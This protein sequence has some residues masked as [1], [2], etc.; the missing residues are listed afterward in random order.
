MCNSYIVRVFI[1]NEVFSYLIFFKE[2]KHGNIIIFYVLAI[3]DHPNLKYREDI[4]YIKS[5]FDRMCQVFF[6]ND[7]V[8]YI[9]AFPNGNISRFGCGINFVFFQSVFRHTLDVF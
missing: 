2:S 8:G 1:L 5:V 9:A 3:L 7:I 4:L 6:A